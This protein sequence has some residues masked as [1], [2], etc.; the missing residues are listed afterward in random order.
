L[1]RPSEARSCPGAC[2]IYPASLVEPEDKEVNDDV[3]HDRT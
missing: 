1:P 3:D 2:S